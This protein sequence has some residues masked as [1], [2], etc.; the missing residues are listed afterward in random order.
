MYVLS[1]LDDFMT[2]DGAGSMTTPQIGREALRMTSDFCRLRFRV[3]MDRQPDLP[4][5]REGK[6][7]P[8]RQHV[9]R[10]LSVNESQIGSAV[11]S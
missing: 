4:T 2:T 9:S 5:S 10:K 3:L 1:N 8:L 6:L 11:R 7:I